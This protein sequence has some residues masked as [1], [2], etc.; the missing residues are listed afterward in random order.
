MGGLSNSKWHDSPWLRLT[1]NVL[2]HAAARGA[3]CGVQLLLLLLLSR[4][5]RCVIRRLVARLVPQHAG[6][7]ASAHPRSFATHVCAGAA[8][9]QISGGAPRVVPGAVAGDAPD[10][11]GRPRG[12]RRRQVLFSSGLGLSLP[13]MLLFAANC[14]ENG[15]S[16]LF[17]FH[18]R[19]PFWR[20]RGWKL[21]RQQA[22]VFFLDSVNQRSPCIFPRTNAGVVRGPR[23]RGTAAS[24]RPPSRQEPKTFQDAAR[25]GACLEH[26]VC[27]AV[28][29][30]AA[31]PSPTP[32]VQRGCDS[33]GKVL[34]VKSCLRDAAGHAVC[35]HRHHAGSRRRGCPRA[36]RFSR[37]GSL[38]RPWCTLGEG[39]PTR[40]DPRC[41][42]R[43][44]VFQRY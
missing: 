5:S 16:L 39:S 7:A 12:V 27:T 33:V 44:S 23:G 32:C 35:V 2:P 42:G 31:R 17:A 21:P 19:V 24:S 10:R 36:G 11:P 9:G 28:V 26:A 1:M 37:P 3:S 30:H 40:F 15:T 25:R 4:A 22:S 8:A 6:Y 29:H 13:S 43:Y 38:P 34:L 14:A 41:G 20:R 18:G